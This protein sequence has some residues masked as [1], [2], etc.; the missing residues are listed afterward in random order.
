MYDECTRRPGSARDQ[1]LT[2]VTPSHPPNQLL[3]NISG[4]L[5]CNCNCNR[6]RALPRA[7]W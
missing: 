3:I 1:P 4:D 6:P 2:P 5:Q 7:G